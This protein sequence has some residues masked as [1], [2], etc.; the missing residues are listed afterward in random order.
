VFPEFLLDQGAGDDFLDTGLRPW[1]LEE[2]CTGKGIDLTLRIQQGY[3][4]SYYFI[5]SFMHEHISW[6]AMRLG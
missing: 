6:H 2:A 1:L 4:H 5:S 3:D